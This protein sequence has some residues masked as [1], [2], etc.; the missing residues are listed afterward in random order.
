MTGRLELILVLV[1]VACGCGGS[2]PGTGDDAGTDADADTD[3]DTDADTDADTDTWAEPT[4]ETLW[5]IRGD[6]LGAAYAVAAGPDGSVAVAGVFRDAID[7]GAGPMASNGENDGFVALFD[8][9]GSCAWSA[10]FGGPLDDG[11]NAVAFD[12]AGEVIV[13]GSFQGTIQVGAET[14]VGAGSY[15]VPVIWLDGQGEPLRALR[16]GGP[17]FDVGFGIATGPGGTLVVMGASGG[18]IDFGGDVLHGTEST[19]LAAFDGDG[20]HVWSR[21]LDEVQGNG[22]A[23]DGSGHTALGGSFSGTI[24]LGTGPLSSLA[25]TDG[26]VA[27]F[28]PGGGTVFA[29]RVGDGSSVFSYAVATGPASEIVLGGMANAQGVSE[30][31]VMIDRF[32]PQ[33]EPLWSRKVGVADYAAANAVAVDGQGH[34]VAAGFVRDGILDFGC[35]PLIAPADPEL[36]FAGEAFLVKLDEEGGCLW[37]RIF[38][39]DGDQGAFGVAV[40]ATARVT[41]AGRFQYGIDFGLGPLVAEHY[42]EPCAAGFAP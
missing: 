4:G 18:P 25:S 12:A 10:R 1:A 6:G 38:G 27:R 36:S 11:A 13:T 22:V 30:S 28:D 16:F 24:D 39:G 26:L 2:P 37:S 8:E 14:L 42:P 40:D 32:S 29:A 31:F 20:G 3:T 34:V 23:V 9:D 21:M 41:L 33:G 17:G 19:F 15:D 35:G 5:A 7:F